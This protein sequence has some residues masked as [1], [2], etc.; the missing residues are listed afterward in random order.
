MHAATVST[1]STL[2]PLPRSRFAKWRALSL[3]LVYLVFGI[4]IAHWKITGKTMAPLELNEVMYTLELGIIT[5]GFLFMCS[6][7]LGS[8]IFGRFFCS[9]ACHIMVL[10]DLCAWILRKCGLER[11]PLR[12]RLLL[13]IPPLTAAYMFL[14][15]QVMRAWHDRALPTFHLATDREGWASLVTNNFW[16]NLP[17]P[18]IIGLTFLTCGFAIVYLLGTRTF[19]TYVCPYG[20]LFG[21]ADRFSPARIRVDQSRCRQCGSCTAVCTSGV[22]VHEEVQQHGMVVN[23]ACLKDLDCVGRCPQQAL[24]YGFG[25]P[26]LL[27]SWRSGGRFGRVPYDFSFGE[28]LLLAAT[29]FVVV[30]IYRGLYSRIPFLLSLAFGVIGA[31][32]VVTTL[33]LWRRPDVSVAQLRLKQAARVL[34]AGKAYVVVVALLAVFTAHCGYVR[35]HEQRGL[36]LTR[37]IQRAP[38]TKTAGELAPIAYAHLVSADRWGLIRNPNVQRCLLAVASR[39]GQYE[40]AVAQARLLLARFP[41]DVAVE[42]QLGQCLLQE[43]RLDEADDHFAAVI[44]NAGGDSQQAR[45][46][47]LEAHQ[48]RAAVALMRGD[49][50][51][52]A[53]QLAAVVSLN[54]ALAGAHAQL[55]GALAE[56][57][58]IEDALREF[59]KAGELDPNLGAAHY[60]RGIMLSRLGREADA[61]AAF[62]DAA[63]LMPLDPDVHN[64][65]GLALLQAGRAHEAADHLRRAVELQPTHAAAHFNLARA[66]QDLGDSATALRHFKLAASLDPQYQPLPQ[67]NPAVS[68]NP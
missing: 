42:L 58:R 7:L 67:G 22:R 47:L 30:L 28:E 17:G 39:L 2:Q 11:K 4:H 34:P 8:L 18:W 60:N 14:W 13:L 43:Q 16:R 37:Q 19:C 33:R 64:N 53:E 63:T 31:L 36:A 12:S 55:G 52:A 41:K 44:A 50:P 48:G 3:S 54:P 24:H 32:A 40:N 46:H 59:T 35:Y 10:Q 65:L 45:S 9:W 1:P 15:P 6:L 38:Y 61:L 51:A 21:L 57:G 26:A 56:L 49:F 62:T 5:A 20:A 68:E 29:F 66:L 23:S 27:R 25:R